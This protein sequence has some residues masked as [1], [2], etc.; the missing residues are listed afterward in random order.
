VSVPVQASGGTVGSHT[1]FEKLPVKN[2]MHA[3]SSGQV[4]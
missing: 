1:L 3:A 2:W 4:E